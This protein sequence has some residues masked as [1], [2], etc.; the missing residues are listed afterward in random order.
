MVRFKDL[1]KKVKAILEECE[2]AR[3]DDEILYLHMLRNEGREK[4]I[5]IDGMT[6]PTFL[7]LGKKLGLTSQESVGRARRKLQRLY[8]ELR[9]NEDT[10]VA[11]ELLEE[12]Y[13]AYAKEVHYVG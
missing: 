8:P 3:N 6:V 12:Q 7:L 1:S 9:A 11:R 4:G 2:D 10:E 13:R 5:D